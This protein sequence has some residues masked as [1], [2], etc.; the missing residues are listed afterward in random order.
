MPLVKIGK[1]TADA[2]IP[3]ADDAE[4]PGD[5][6]ILVYAARF[7][8]DAEA[9][10]RRAGPTGVSGPDGVWSARLAEEPC[11]LADDQDPV[12]PRTWAWR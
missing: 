2:F 6:A 3:V 11:A 8:E 5:G 1:I 9:L 10:S 7:L 12:S 4:I